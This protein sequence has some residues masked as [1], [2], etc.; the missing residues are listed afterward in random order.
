M[1]K[2]L[3]LHTISPQ[4]N[5]DLLI[6]YTSLWNECTVKFW[7]K[8]NKPWVIYEVR[9]CRFTKWVNNEFLEKKAMKAFEH[10]RFSSAYKY[11]EEK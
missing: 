8:T 11:F 3:F 2:A 7:E 6:G 9:N 1:K 4:P 10:L 5:D